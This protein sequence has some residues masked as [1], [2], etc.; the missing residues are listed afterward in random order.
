MRVYIR[1]EDNNWL[2]LLMNP[3]FQS[4]NMGLIPIQA[5]TTLQS[6]T[7]TSAAVAS[8]V[9]LPDKELRDVNTAI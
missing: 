8:M 6:T 3:D 5:T 2:V 9:P 4:G 7:N 1:K